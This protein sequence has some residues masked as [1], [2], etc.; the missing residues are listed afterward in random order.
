LFSLPAL[1]NAA[2]RLIA[3]LRPEDSVAVYNFSNAITELQPFTA[4]K[5]SAKRSVLGT[6]AYGDTALYDALARVGQDLVGRAGKKVI[7][8]FTD[9]KDNSST[10]NPDDA[11]QRAKANGVPIYTIAQGEAIGHKDLLEQLAG[12]SK[13]TGGEAFAIEKPS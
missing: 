13:A 12:I 4:D 11:I 2:L 5:S 3:E 8:L 1:K 10:L 7:V 9:G 6:R